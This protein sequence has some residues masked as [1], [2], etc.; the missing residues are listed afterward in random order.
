MRVSTGARKDASCPGFIYSLRW[1]V[2]RSEYLLSRSQLWVA[3][4]QAAND[5]TLYG[6]DVT[7]RCQETLLL[8]GED[9]SG[10]FFAVKYEF[11]L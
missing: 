6:C 8:V 5:V 4:G 1:A 7:M 2:L 3:I 9:S 10:F 11:S